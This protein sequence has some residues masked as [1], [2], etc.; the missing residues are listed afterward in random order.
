MAKPDGNLDPSS[1]TSDQPRE[2]FVTLVPRLAKFVWHLVKDPRVPWQVKASLIG[3][4]AYLAS[5]IDI[6]PDWIP[7]AG[8]LDD[9]LILGFVASYVLAR[10]PIEVV[11]E[12]WGED[13]ETLE[14]LQKRLRVKRKKGE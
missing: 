7:G 12:H 10:V 13:V 8:Y 5:P 4:A 3:L 14:R 11:K 9:V 2:S 1:F 6:I